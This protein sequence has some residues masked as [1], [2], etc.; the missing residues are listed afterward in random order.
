MENKNTTSKLKT[1][2]KLINGLRDELAK[3]SISFN[4]EKAHSFF[5]SME[6]CACEMA[7]EI[8]A[9]KASQPKEPIYAVS[10]LTQYCDYP[11]RDAKVD[12]LSHLIKS[13]IVRL[14]DSDSER[15]KMINALCS[16]F[17]LIDAPKDE[18]LRINKG[19]NNL[20]GDLHY[21]SGIE[22]SPTL[23]AATFFGRSYYASG[24]KAGVIF[25]GI[26]PAN[27][28]K[29]ESERDAIAAISSINE[30]SAPGF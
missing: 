16:S 21:I 11:L 26:S 3:P 1:I 6:E 27:G 2:F 15:Q 8:A 9:L 30:K 19:G 13:G 7:N 18:T 12:V 28:F 22:L 20:F 17:E 25:Y 5:E 29:F 23:T 14:D 10:A 24:R 4:P